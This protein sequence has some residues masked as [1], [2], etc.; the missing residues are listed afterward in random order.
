M[1]MRYLPLEENA[2]TAILIKDTLFKSKD[3]TKEYS[4]LVHTACC[5]VTLEY[6]GKK[7]S[8]KFRKAYIEQLL[9][10]LCSKHIDYILCADGEYFKTLSGAKKITG[11]IGEVYPVKGA[12]HI[13]CMYIPSYGSF[14]V[15]P[16]AMQLRDRIIGLF[17]KVTDGS[18]QRVG[19]DILRDVAY[20]KTL[21]EIRDALA[22]LH[23]YDALTAD[24]EAFSL[25][26]YDAGIASI[27]FGVDEHT[28]VSFLV[29]YQPCPEYEIQVWDKKDKKFKTKLGYGTNVPNAA[30]RALLKEFF[31]AYRGKM[32][33]HNCSYDVTVLVYQLWMTDLLD[34]EG[35]HTGRAIL[36]RHVEDTQL[37][38]YLATN[39]CAGN[40]LGLKEQSQEFT[41]NYAEDV[42]DVRMLTVD[43]LLRYNAV[44]ICATW[45]VM[46][47]HYDTLVFD[48][49]LT[50]YEDIFKPAL[51][52][53]I[54]MQLTGMCLDL[55]RVE[56]VKEEL[57]QINIAAYKVLAKSDTVIQFIE[58][59]IAAEVAKRNAE[60]KTKVI[61]K[62]EAKFKFNHNSNLQLQTLIFGAMGLPAIDTTPTG[63]PATGGKTLKKL[64]NHTDNEEYQG[65]L[66]ALI[67]LSA[68]EKILGSFIYSFQHDHVVCSDGIARIYGSF[69]LGG[70]VSARLS[71]SNPNVQQIPSGSRF[72]KLVKSCFVAPKGM[73][74]AMSDFAALEDV[75]N[76]LLTQDPNKQKVLLD[77]F[78]G[79]SFRAYSFWREKFPHINEH[80]P[81]SVN[82]IANDFDSIRS[83][84][85][86]VH[87]ALQYLGTWA[88]LVNNCGFSSDEA[89]MIEARYKDLYKV[90]FDWVDTRI[91]E[92]SLRGY[93][94]GAFG[95]R[96]RAPLLNQVILGNTRTPTEAA[97]ES[98]TLGNAIS[99]Q[100]Y[101]L[102]NGRASAEFMQRV[103]ASEFKHDIWLCA[104]I[105]DAIYLYIKDSFEV[106]KWVNDNLIDCMKWQELPEL[107]HD[108]IKL[109]SQLD[110]GYPNWS[111]CFTL[112]NHLTEEEIKAKCILEANK[113]RATA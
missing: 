1:N 47:K 62:T 87:F 77:G 65:V 83:D 70:T 22:R 28:A 92:A 75:V 96:I 37:I 31:E 109:S 53:I 40:K 12:E 35:L 20:P 61:D 24:I 4:D 3:L 78:D 55:K 54:E 2:T 59:S 69:K 44:D 15:N 113:R 100:S 71:A 104:H 76:T 82:S 16:D 52:D 25:K 79:H 41:G 34:R 68:V 107:H 74:F 48:D 98:R 57:T 102:L 42:K 106:I 50:M 90:S 112:D 45:F 72:G 5:A 14:F 13:Q 84:A 26:H 99:G 97:A 81:V 11:C 63:K 89:K 80:D 105:H 88:T 103:R 101:C 85:K 73:L 95:L 56:E 66:K 9:K 91:E 8:A 108:K 58:D 7:P 94:T 27:G 110:I 32:I 39:S 36:L 18:F 10:F 86:P 43:K 33:W 30:V 6:D 60:Y 64:I 46:N 23:Q 38:T 51:Y 93:A 49:Q 19:T 111:K 67:D 21:S 17:N 29:D